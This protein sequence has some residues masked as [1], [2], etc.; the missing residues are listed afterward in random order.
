[1]VTYWITGLLVAM[2]SEGKSGHLLDYRP[3]CSNVSGGQEWSAFGRLTT[4]ISV[5]S[6]NKEN[7]FSCFFLGFTTKN[8]RNWEKESI[9]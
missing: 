3:T 2:P 6:A 8:S 9:L 1:M 7:A 4:K 5:A